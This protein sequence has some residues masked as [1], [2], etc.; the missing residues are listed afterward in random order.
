M[1]GSMLEAFGPVWVC[2]VEEE[3]LFCCVV[4]EDV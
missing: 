3:V 2:G 4:V 1:F